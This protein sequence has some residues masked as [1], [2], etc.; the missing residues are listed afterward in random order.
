[1]YSRH[2]KKEIVAA[3]TETPFI[4][5]V[6]K[7]FGVARST[8][9]KWLKDDKNFSSDVVIALREGKRSMNELALS[10]LVKRV[11]DGHFPAIRYFLQ[12]NHGDYR[13]PEKVN[14]VAMWNARMSALRKKKEE[15]PYETW[16]PESKFHDSLST[17]QEIMLELLLEYNSVEEVS[18]DIR[19]EYFAKVLEDEFKSITEAEQYLKQAIQLE[20]ESAK[21]S[22]SAD[23]NQ[24]SG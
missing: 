17:K 2:V 3:L 6:C 21:P 13:P 19:S 4:Y 23:A 20:K 16:N 11:S 9:Y 7:K 14:S 5:R 24:T 18:I 22:E 12:H 1:M 15:A 8:F 10:S